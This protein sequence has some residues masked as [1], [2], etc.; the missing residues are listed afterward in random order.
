M[1]V[2]ARKINI[3]KFYSAFRP[4]DHTLILACAWP[5]NYKIIIMSDFRIYDRYD[6]I[7]WLQS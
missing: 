7:V 1:L 3:I 2:G 4:N 6:S 5:G